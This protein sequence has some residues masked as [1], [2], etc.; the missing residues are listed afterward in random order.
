[1]LR[2][3][4]FT[5]WLRDLNIKKIGADVFGKLRNVMLEENEVD[6]IVRKT[7]Y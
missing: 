3:E 2:L 7:N 5:V 6:K 4:H 1:M